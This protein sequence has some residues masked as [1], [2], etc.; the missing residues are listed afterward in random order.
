M[1]HNATA[2]PSAAAPPTYPTVATT[3]AVRAWSRVAT[4]AR[5]VIGAL[6]R[7]ADVVLGTAGT[8]FVAG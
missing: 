1:S 4:P 7:A 2:P 5:A 8:T 3:P 6:D